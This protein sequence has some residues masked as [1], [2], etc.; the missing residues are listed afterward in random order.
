[1]TVTFKECTEE[2][3]NE[4]L[5]VVPPV[6]SVFSSTGFLV[7]EPWRHNDDGQPMFAPFLHYRGKFWEGDGPMTVAEFR[8]ID[9]KVATAPRTTPEE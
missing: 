4:M 6:W 1:M 7:G 5:G 3:Y 2:R 8:A 9:L